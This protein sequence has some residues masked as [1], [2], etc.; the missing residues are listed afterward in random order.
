MSEYQHNIHLHRPNAQ[1]T[2]DDFK[3]RQLEIVLSNLSVSSFL[4]S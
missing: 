4:L 1:K 2:L 3:T